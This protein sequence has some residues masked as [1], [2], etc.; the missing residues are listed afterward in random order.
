MQ[1]DPRANDWNDWN[2]PLDG[3]S[4]PHVSRGRLTV[5]R[6]TPLPADT[7]PGAPSLTSLPSLPAVAEPVERE[8]RF[9]ADLVHARAAGFTDDARRRGEEHSMRIWREGCH[10]ALLSLVRASTMQVSAEVVSFD[11]EGDEYHV[12]VRLRPTTAPQVH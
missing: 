8:L 5:P 3:A 7:V 6:F 11:L 9:P 2:P 12:A 4:T 10:E 1:I